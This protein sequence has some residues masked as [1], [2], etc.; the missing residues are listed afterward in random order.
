MTAGADDHR[1]PRIDA[2]GADEVNTKRFDHVRVSAALS[3]L[4]PLHRDVIRKAYY[5][6]WTTDHI[7]ADLNM[8]EPVIKSQL[9]C[10]VHNVQRLLVDPTLRRR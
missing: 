9:H 10:A 2:S 1:F 5:L 7:A 6:G 3:Q 4:Q 8:A